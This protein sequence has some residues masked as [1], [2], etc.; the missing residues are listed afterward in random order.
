MVRVD[1][2][3]GALRHTMGIIALVAL[4]RERVL[5]TVYVP[6]IDAR[7]AALLGGV[8][9]MPVPTLAALVQHLRGEVPIEPAPEGEDLAFDDDDRPG[10][11]LADV[12]GQEHARRALEVAAAGGHNLYRFGTL[13]LQ[14]DILSSEV[15]STEIVGVGGTGGVVWRSHGRREE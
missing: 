6:T 4:A 9:V 13:C 12:K 15:R 2:L 8:R 5:R 1:L 11:D 10:G 3:A 7:E 14:C